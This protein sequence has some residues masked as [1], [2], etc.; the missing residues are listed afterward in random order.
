M[1]FTHRLRVRFDECDVQGIVYNARYLAYADITFI[2]WWREL[3]GSYAAA[4]AAGCD[5]V[6]AEAT[7]RYLLPIKADELVDISLRVTYIGKTSLHTEMSLESSG[8]L[9]ATVVSR[10]VFVDSASLRPVP[11][12]DHRREKLLRYGG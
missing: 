4:V 8:E 11:V 3:A 2:E 1:R 6:L 7:V 12:A 5:T 9:M 10:Y